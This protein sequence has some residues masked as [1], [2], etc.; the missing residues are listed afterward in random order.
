MKYLS[1]LFSLLYLILYLSACNVP[2]VQESNRPQTTFF[3]LKGFFKA[4]A[5]YLKE[6]GV[7]IQKTIEHNQTKETQ[8]VLPKDWEKELLLFSESDINKPS[9][10]DKYDL[11]STNRDNGL[12]LLHYKAIDE[13]LSIQVLDV[14]LKG[15]TVHSILIVKKVS[16]QVYESQQHLTYFPRKSYHIKKSQDVTLFDKDDYTIEAKYIYH[17]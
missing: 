17:E 1:K 15:E 3:D 13:N 5:S 6:Q 16:N 10:K 11:V 4:E 2:S 8:T 14:E 12:T 9:W 7:K